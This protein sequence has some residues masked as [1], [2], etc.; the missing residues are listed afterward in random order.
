MR[1]FGAGLVALLRMLAKPVPL[2]HLCSWLPCKSLNISAPKPSC[3]RNKPKPQYR[4]V[5]PPNLSLA[6]VFPNRLDYIF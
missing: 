4:S 1:I 5:I 2:R 6:V 3:C